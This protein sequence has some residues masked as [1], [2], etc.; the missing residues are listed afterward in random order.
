MRP[1]QLLSV[2]G[3]AAMTTVLGVSL[4][5][6]GEDAPGAE[7]L[8]KD[9]VDI[10]SST[11]R[12]QPL[13]NGVAVYTDRSFKMDDVP[14]ALVGATYLRFPNDFKRSRAGGATFKL[15]RPATV[16]LCYDGRAEA[17]P[18]W[19]EVMGLKR[20]AMKMTVGAAAEYPFFVFARDYPAGTVTL[21]PN[22]DENGQGGGC[23][24][25]VA[26]KE[27]PK[28]AEQT[29]LVSDIGY[30][31]GPAFHGFKFEDKCRT[32]ADRSFSLKNVP[33]ALAGAIYIPTLQGAR[34][35][36]NELIAFTLTARAEVY[37]G[38]P[39]GK[40]PA[41]ALDL[42]FEESELEVTVTGLNRSSDF[43]IPFY[44]CELKPGRHVFGGNRDGGRKDGNTY[45]VVVK[46]SPRENALGVASGIP[47]PRPRKIVPK[48]PRVVWAEDADQWTVT[49]YSGNSSVGPYP[50]QG[51]IREV[52]VP[53]GYFFAADGT[54]FA[55]A[56]G[57]IG[58]VRNERQYLFAGV[59]GVA[60]HRDG[61]A[62]TAIFGSI[63]GMAPDRKGG[64]FVFDKGNLCF[65]QLYKDEAGAWHVRTVAGVPGKQG[66]KDGAAAEALFQNPWN[67]A[68]DSAGRIYTFDN[69]SL[70]RIADGRVETLN[71]KGGGGYKEGPIETARFSIS[72]GG[73]CSIDEDDNIYLVDRSNH[74]FR[75]IDL[76]KG[77][78]SNFCGQR[79]SS[80]GW[81]GPAMLASFGAS[82]GGITYDPVRKC[83][84]V[85]GDDDVR[86]RRLKDGWVKSL[87]G[88]KNSASPVIGPAKTIGAFWIGVRGID[89]K[90]DIYFADGR[91]KGI[92][93]KATFTGKR[94]E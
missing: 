92:M 18:A 22:N 6:A 4:A 78:V 77:E 24:Y 47:K 9:V 19:I 43:T 87:I 13:K 57:V 34:T 62:S 81:D 27:K 29:P 14:E 83:Y 5:R 89:L 91:H 8:V 75:R 17:F 36:S 64:Y 68:V 86:I 88:G 31:R 23:M 69:N 38:C 65:R 12:G 59:P 61:P 73:G 32:Y 76:K 56:G 39:G 52:N 46:G 55:L 60:G 53:G 74:C 58:V 54:Q 40:A 11:Y 26:V 84:Y 35:R 42:G 41:W 10:R 16:Y 20:T 70:L 45:V 50:Q 90:G 2:L 21:G 48:N 15:A 94:E 72:P 71:P 49:V 51:P 80:D 79:Q 93:R 1:V 82:P 37:L 67:M 28:E 3:A 66:R 44:R 25:G 63:A 85:H 33:G 7:P 30:H